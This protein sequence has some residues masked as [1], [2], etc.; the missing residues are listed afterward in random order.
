M[1]LT[2]AQW[3]VLEPLIPDPP[4][5]EDGRGRPWRNPRDVL[6]GILWVLRTGAPWHDLPEGYPPYQTC[7]RRFQKWVEEGVLGR[8]LK[9]LVEDLQNRGGL[10]LSECYIDG[11]FIGV[12]KGER[13]WARPSGVRAQS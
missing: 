6:N 13:P 4:R 12:K 8:V 9:A 1:N 3:E 10:D 11:T 2:D 7:H 5:R